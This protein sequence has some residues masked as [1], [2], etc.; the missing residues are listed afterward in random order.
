MSDRSNRSQL[1]IET[2]RNVKLAEIIYG[3]ISSTN[4]LLEWSQY[5]DIYLMTNS[6]YITPVLANKHLENLVRLLNV[7]SAESTQARLFPLL[8]ESF[9][10]TDECSDA[11][12]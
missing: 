8:Y 7:T 2:T 9:I 11:F 4:F 5:D 12:S 6:D 3:K 1:Y 10:S